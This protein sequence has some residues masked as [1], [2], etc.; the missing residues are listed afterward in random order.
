MARARPPIQNSTAR[1]GDPGTARFRKLVS[2]GLA[3]PGNAETTAEVKASRPTRKMGGARAAITRMAA[4]PLPA[5]LVPG[6][7]SVAE[8]LLNRT[9][10]IVEPSHART[11]PVVSVGDRIHSIAQ[12]RYEV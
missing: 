4:P 12:G 5:A 10:E 8:D 7:P 11:A 6:R 1:G 2:R 9:P 3:T